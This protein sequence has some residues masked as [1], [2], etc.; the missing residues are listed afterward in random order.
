MIENSKTGPIMLK[1][2]IDRMLEYT[3]SGINTTCNMT[4]MD[5]RA[6]AINPR[7]AGGLD[8]VFVFDASSSIKK[9]DFKLSIGFA[10][11]LVR[12][13]GTSWK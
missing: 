12:V 13:L 4:A 7:H 9:G 1:K 3:C 11:K 2:N 6:R 10:Q 5:M 8:I